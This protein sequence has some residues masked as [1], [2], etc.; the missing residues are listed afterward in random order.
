PCSGPIRSVRTALRTP[1][2]PRGE[3]M[4]KKWVAMAGGSWGIV[5]VAALNL[6]GI[7]RSVAGD[8][9]EP[10]DDRRGLVGADFTGKI[11]SVG[12]TGRSSEGTIIVSALEISVTRA[13]NTM[14]V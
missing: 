12:K 9:K 10:G 14:T 6:G 7:A 8:D 4:A 13:Y 1:R 2:G 11:L 3:D 5:L